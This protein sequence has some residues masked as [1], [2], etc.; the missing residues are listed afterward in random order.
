VRLDH[1]LFV[2]DHALISL[3]HEGIGLVRI[4]ILPRDANQHDAYS[5]LLRPGDSLTD[6]LVPG[7]QVGGRHRSLAGERDEVKHDQRVDA[8]LSVGRLSAEP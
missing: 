1:R 2:E 7:N 4:A 5:H 6:I 3:P 8:L